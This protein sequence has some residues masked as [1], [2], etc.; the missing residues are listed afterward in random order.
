[1]NTRSFL[2]FILPTALIVAG[3]ATTASPR[4]SLSGGIGLPS[5]IDDETGATVY[6]LTN[7]EARDQVIYQTHPQWAHG[8][9]YLIFHSERSGDWLPHALE[10]ATGEIQPLVP[11]PVGQIVVADDRGKIV[12]IRDREVHETDIANAFDRGPHSLVIGELPTEYIGLSGDVSL[13]PDERTLYLGVVLEEDVRWGLASFD[14]V[15]GDWLLLHELDFKIGHTQANPVRDGVVMF[16]HET[17]GDAPQR[18]WIYDENDGG[19]R[20]LYP[21]KNE[22]WVTHEAWWGKDWAIFTIWP[23]DEAH[24][25][26]SHGIVSVNSRTGAVRHHVE[27]RA[28]HTHAS[29]N[30]KWIMGDD[31]DRNIWLINARSGERT[32]L[33]QSHNGEGFG[34]H[35]HAS[36]TPDSRGIVFNSSKNGHEDIFLVMLPKGK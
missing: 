23:Y 30:R 24:E 28:W 21:E 26:L 16:C 14:M 17:G 9:K 29:P 25:Q 33:T 1:M 7:D 2:V 15:S 20:P 8:M 4:G 34:T 13:S 3:C 11:A 12:S 36:F 31:F 35:P 10:L 18:M 22:E 32:L 27:Y 6:M 19:I 5:Y